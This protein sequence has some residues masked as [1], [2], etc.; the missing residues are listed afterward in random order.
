MIIG[1]AYTA[2]SACAHFVNAAAHQTAQG[3]AVAAQ[4]MFIDLKAKAPA[5]ATDS[6]SKLDKGFADLK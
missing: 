5:N 2:K 6:I 3:L 1:M 4:S